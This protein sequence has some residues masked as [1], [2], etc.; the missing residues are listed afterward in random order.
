MQ[1]VLVTGSA[2]FIRGCYETPGDVTLVITGLDDT[3]GSGASR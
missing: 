2:G 3:D 1:K